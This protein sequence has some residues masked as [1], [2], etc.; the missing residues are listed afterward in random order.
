MIGHTGFLTFARKV[1]SQLAATE[2]SAADD[3]E[4]G[5]SAEEP[6]QDFV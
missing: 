5:T 1:E 6:S 2:E 4:E 3:F